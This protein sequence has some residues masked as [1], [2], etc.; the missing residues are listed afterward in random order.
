MMAIIARRIEIVK[1]IATF[2]YL[3]K[4]G[5]MNEDII[6]KTKKSKDINGNNAMHLAY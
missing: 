1:M 3:D 4:N 2:K 5:Q 6:K